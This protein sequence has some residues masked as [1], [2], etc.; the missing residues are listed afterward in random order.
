VL[1]PQA[2]A[3][4]RS[5]LARDSIIHARVL[6]SAQADWLL[7]LNLVP[8][9]ASRAQVLRLRTPTAQLRRSLHDVVAADG[10]LR[11]GH[12]MCLEPDATRR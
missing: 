9:L 6:S 3:S 11:A 2:L 12:G 4:L 8:D 1:A 7:S 5:R 10:L